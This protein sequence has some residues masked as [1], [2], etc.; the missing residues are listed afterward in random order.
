MRRVAR[1]TEARG[2]PSK[3]ITR[4]KDDRGTLARCWSCGGPGHIQRNCTRAKAREPEVHEQRPS[5]YSQRDFT[6]DKP[7]V[8]KEQE[9]PSSP[10]NSGNGH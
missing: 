9:Q 2:V 7:R 8:H 10:K 3:E 6:T 5:C 1:K 4:G